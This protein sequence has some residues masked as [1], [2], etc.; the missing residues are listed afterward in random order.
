MKNLMMGIR[1]GD[2]SKAL[3]NVKTA[4]DSYVKVTVTEKVTEMENDDGT[5]SKCKVLELSQASATGG[6]VSEM[7]GYAVAINIEANGSIK[8]IPD[9]VEGESV[10]FSL[11]ELITFSDI[12]AED[13][14]SVMFCLNRDRGTCAVTLGDKEHPMT[15]ALP[16]KAESD[17]IALPDADKPFGSFTVTAKFLKHLGAMSRAVIIGST[18]V[19]AFSLGEKPNYVITDGS[20]AAFGELGATDYV[21]SP[22]KARYYGIAAECLRSIASSCGKGDISFSFTGNGDVAS[23]VTISY[24]NNGLCTKYIRSVISA[25]NV[26]DEMYKKLEGMYNDAKGTV[27]HVSRKETLRVLK[28]LSIGSDDKKP[29]NAIT[30]KNGQV[31]ISSSD[32]LNNKSVI[33]GTVDN[34]VECTH[35]FGTKR[36]SN[37]LENLNLKTLEG[38]DEEQPAT[39]AVSNIFVFK[40]APE[41]SRIILAGVSNRNNSVPKEEEVKPK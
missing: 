9:K 22:E 34:S 31:I 40:D 36:F 14:S 25:G 5:K 11:K 37:I 21:A 41:G 15:M 12:L 16:L 26:C 19:V 17:V 18:E 8:Q 2:L 32:D 23:M 35:C 20:G 1:A 33:R 29:T 7:A 6:V 39:I 27:V 13:N 30:V 28:L 38:T 10:V 3:K 24:E 4:G